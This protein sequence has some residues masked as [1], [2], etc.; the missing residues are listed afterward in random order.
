M[1]I[2]AAR[3]K[4]MHVPPIAFFIT[5]YFGSGVIIATAFIHVCPDCLL[6]CT[7]LMKSKLLAPANEALTSPCLSGPITEYSWV[8]GIALMTVFTMFFIELMASRFEI[9][10]KPDLDASDPTKKMLGGKDNYS[11][12]AVALEEGMFENFRITCYLKV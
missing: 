6:P 9:F 5:K 11:D 4:R 3:S 7:M 10:G 2:I 1:P 12:N 8:E